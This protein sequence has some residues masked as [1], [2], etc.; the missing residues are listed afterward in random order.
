MISLYKD[1]E[2]KKIF[3]RNT[4]MQSS[5]TAYQFKDSGDKIASLQQKVV[6]LEEELAVFKVLHV[7]SNSGIVFATNNEQ[8][9]HATVFSCTKKSGSPTIS[10][11]L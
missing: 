8:F 5:M 1:P 3:S 11:R 10:R 4:V 2:G 7:T 9:S 6:Q